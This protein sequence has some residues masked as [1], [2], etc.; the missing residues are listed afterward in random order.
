[1]K[2]NSHARVLAIDLHPRHFGFAVVRSP[3]RV[4]HWGVR[5]S[6]RRTKKHPEVLVGRL[7]FLLNFWEP[8]AVLILAGTR[9]NRDVQLLCRQIRKEVG[10]K[11]VLVIKKS[12]DGSLGRS[13]HERAVAIAA[14]FP[15]IRWKLPS[16]RKPWDSEHYSMTM[17]EALSIA[18]AHGGGKKRDA[19]AFTCK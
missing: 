12:P 2:H 3:D 14:R 19:A 1:M 11:S 5:R 15:E 9:R 4:L 17:F 18:V 6:Y 16:K 10:A 13:K 8:D 7:R